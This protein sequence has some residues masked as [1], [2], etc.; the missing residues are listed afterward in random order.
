MPALQYL[1]RSLFNL[2]PTK[3]DNKLL[4]AVKRGDG[5]AVRKLVDAHS[6]R[7]YNLALRILRHPHDAEDERRAAEMPVSSRK[8]LYA[9]VAMKL[10]TSKNK[11]K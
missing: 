1:Q 2:M 9:T 11:A 7:L 3:S 5:R 6:P 8:R 10:K 4:A